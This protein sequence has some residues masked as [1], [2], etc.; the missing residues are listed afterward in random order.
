MPLK[1][2][3]DVPKIPKTRKRNLE[4]FKNLIPAKK[5]E[6][7]DYKCKFFFDYDSTKDISYF[8]V[9]IETT[10][11]FGSFSYEVS[12]EY[13][14]NKNVID[15]GILGLTTKINNVPLVAPAFNNI[16]IDET[17]GEFEINIIKYDGCINSAKIKLNLFEKNIQI[18]ETSVLEKENNRL[19]CIFEVDSEKSVFK[20]I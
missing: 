11:V 2:Q 17:N 14:K 20:I 19:F 10:V 6:K 3:K 15:I 8:V 7:I 5:D 13:M 9:R 16:L 12:V 4:V 18:L 1:K